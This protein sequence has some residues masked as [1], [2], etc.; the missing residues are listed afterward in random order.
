[1]FADGVAGAARK[2]GR[3]AGGTALP[4]EASQKAA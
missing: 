2:F 4:A 1:M 3:K